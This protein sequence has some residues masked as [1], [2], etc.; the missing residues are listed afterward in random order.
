M[1]RV[2]YFFA[3]VFVFSL[4]P[5]LEA[6]WGEPDEA[7]MRKKVDQQVTVNADGS[8]TRDVA[9]AVTLLDEQARRDD[10]HFSRVF[11]ATRQNVKILS[12]HVRTQ[13]HTYTVPD[14]CIETRSL[15][16]DPMGIRNDT[17][18]LLPF[19]NINVGATL[20]CEWKEETQT[21]LPQCFGWNTLFQGDILWEKGSR[22]EFISSLPLDFK[23]N[24][25]ENVLQVSE[26]QQ[27]GIQTLTVE[28]LKPVYKHLSSQYA[29]PLD[30]SA[31]PLFSIA[32]KDWMQTM[33]RFLHDKYEKVMS[34]PLPLFLSNTVEDLKNKKAENDTSFESQVTTILEALIENVRYMGEWS[35]LQG[36]YEPRNF[37]TVVKTKY[38]DCKDFSALLVASLRALGFQANITYVERG[39]SYIPA[40]HLPSPA[41]FDHAMVKAI[42]PSGGIHWLDGTNHIAMVSDIFADIADR[43]CWV[44]T[45]E[46]LIGDYIPFMA[47]VRHGALKNGRSVILRR[48]RIPLPAH[49]SYSFLCMVRQQC[50]FDGKKTASLV[51]LA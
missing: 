41:A 42:S 18:I 17:Q 13:D 15:A 14:A 50:F 8:Y 48:I 44:L 37:N 12:A 26:K 2:R 21:A 4:L 30:F 28:L 7:S 45:H 19:P 43:P 16:S 24:D 33:G 49:L 35:S 9:Q 27:D 10:A 38:G 23:V 36:H 32:S 47:Q 20:V 29:R 6:R 31:V 39:A 1:E 3:G 22:F 34:Q 46:G 5:S 51:N 25:P 40:P 11:D